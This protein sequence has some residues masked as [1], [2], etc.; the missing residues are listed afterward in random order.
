MAAVHPSLI[1]H[2]NK[3]FI[4][5]K[6]FADILVS[7]KYDINDERFIDNFD[8]IIDELNKINQDNKQG[9][10]LIKDLQER[11]H[12]QVHNIID[13]QQGGSMSI[14]TPIGQII[15]DK[16]PDLLIHL[17]DKLNFRNYFVDKLVKGKIDINDERFIDSFDKI[18]DEL[19]QVYPNKKQ[20]FLLIDELLKAKHFD[21]EDL[22]KWPQPETS[23]LLSP[24]SQKL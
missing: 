13:W 18:T 12:I 9:Q 1:A 15:K 11:G 17:N 3:K 10:Q 24:I 7:N 14:Y 2:L 5:R 16:Y 6:L 8:Q 20:G 23:S 21:K 19:N 22:I 4:F